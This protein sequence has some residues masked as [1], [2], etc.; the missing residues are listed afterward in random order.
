MTTTYKT[1]EPENYEGLRE[2]ITGVFLEGECYAF[3]IALYRGTDWPMTGLMENRVVRHA[4]VRDPKGV[5]HDAR[6]A[7]NEEELGRPFGFSPPY[8]LKPV[9]EEELFSIKPVTEF[10]IDFA[11]R[12]AQI[13][14]PDLPWKPDT[15][16]IKIRSFAEE[17]ENLSRKYGLWVRGYS[18]GMPPLVAEECGKEKGYELGFTLDG[19]HTINRVF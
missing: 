2:L 19:S 14:W 1:L 10:T 15:L 13:L 5:F 11:S 17:L 8:V 3:A 18:P 9:S 7:V 16:K 6:G 12:K 4:V